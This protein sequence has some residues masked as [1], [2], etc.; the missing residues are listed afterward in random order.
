MEPCVMCSM[1]LVHSRIRRVFYSLPYH[2]IGVG[3]LNTNLQM[4]NL[5]S[6]NHKYNVFNGILQ[7]E[8][9][10]ILQSLNQL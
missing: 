3:G 9:N 5:K 2:G 6:L 1:A 7:K 4:N 10:E 8:A